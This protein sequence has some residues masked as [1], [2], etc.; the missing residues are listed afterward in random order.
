MFHQV[1]PVGPFDQGTRLVTP[2]AEF[3][4]VADDSGDWAITDRGETRFRAP[5]DDYRVSVLWKADVYK[6]EAE[7]RRQKGESLSLEDVARIFDEDL[8]ARGA[9]FGFPFE[10]LE[11]PALPA[12][13]QGVYPEA[14]PVGASA[15]V[16]G[17]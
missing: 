5:L 16:M 7:M 6:N 2:R 14:V 1:G 8:K 11:D 17:P 9:G 12:A 10:R 15:S 13:I 4:P 3:A